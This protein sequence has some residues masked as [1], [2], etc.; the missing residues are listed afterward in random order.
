M[1]CS[2]TAL[3][4]ASWLFAQASS[5]MPIA[6]DTSSGLAESFTWN[7]V[8][9]LTTDASSPASARASRH[10]ATAIAWWCD[11]TPSDGVRPMP[12]MAQLIATGSGALPH[13]VVRW[14]ATT[15]G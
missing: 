11:R 7:V 2:A 9:P 4:P 14:A 13:G 8:M 6:Q 3:P 15:R 12:T 5:S 10:A 1:T